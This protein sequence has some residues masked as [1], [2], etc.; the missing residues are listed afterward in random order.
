MA[1]NAPLAKLSSAQSLA[2]QIVRGGATLAALGE[3]FKSTPG[4]EVEDEQVGYNLNP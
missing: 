4:Q 1:A 2:E 3:A